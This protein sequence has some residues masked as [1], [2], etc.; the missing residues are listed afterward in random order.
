[1]KADEKST[2]IENQIRFKRWKGRKVSIDHGVTHINISG[3]IFARDH[4][5]ELITNEVERKDI[6][7]QTTASVE[8]QNGF[9]ASVDPGDGRIEIKSDQT[10]L[11]R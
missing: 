6:Y 9:S 8:L 4:A 5:L 11:K 3:C 1:M 2:I 10:G 7:L